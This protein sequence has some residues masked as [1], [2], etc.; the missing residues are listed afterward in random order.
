MALTSIP[1]SNSL[2]TQTRGTSEFPDDTWNAIPGLNN[3]DVPFPNQPSF[4]TEAP[5][6]YSVFHPGSPKEE[7]LFPDVKPG[8]DATSGSQQV[9]VWQSSQNDVMNVVFGELQSVS[10]F[11]GLQLT[12]H[13]YV[14][15]HQQSA[16]DIYPVIDPQTKHD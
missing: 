1:S 16:V 2:E 5:M 13:V 10:P 15:A 6:E 8:D 3:F 4:K 14:A 11:P 9:D 7:Y 12:D